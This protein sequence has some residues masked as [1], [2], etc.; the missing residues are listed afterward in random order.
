MGSG[1][2][3]FVRMM[4]GEQASSPSFALQQIYVVNGGE[5]Q[6]WDLDRINSIEEL[7]GTGFFDI[8]GED[9]GKKLILIE[10]ANRLEE[11]GRSLFAPSG[12]TAQHLRW[13]RD[14]EK[15]LLEITRLE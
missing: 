13:R 6:H 10:W 1:K 4:V 15:R 11:F 8:F 12:W 9:D 2:T 7:E 3:T 14:G 5:I